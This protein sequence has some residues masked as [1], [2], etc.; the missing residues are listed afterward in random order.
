[1]FNVLN[2]PNFA[3][4]SPVIDAPTFGIATQMLGQSLT[5]VTG[6]GGLN[7]LYQTGGP[8]SLQFALKL[9]F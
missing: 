4:P 6:N 2:H 8:R 9:M 3:P 5:D 7:P 1:M